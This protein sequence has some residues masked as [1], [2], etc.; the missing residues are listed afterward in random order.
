MRL[1]LLLFFCWII[2]SSCQ[3]DDIDRLEDR[4]EGTWNFTEAR[5]RNTNKP[6]GTFY[7]IYSYYDGDQMT[8]FKDESMVYTEANGDVWDGTWTYYAVN[9]GED[10]TYIL[11][12]VMTNSRGT[13]KHYVWNT[14]GIWQPNRLELRS[15]DSDFEHCFVLWRN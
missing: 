2:F 9:S 4:L 12:V 1:L 6:F 7:S 10:R 5:Q 11:S 15:E 14:N 8:F 13:V 3:R